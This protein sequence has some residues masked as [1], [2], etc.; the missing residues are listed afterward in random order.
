MAVEDCFLTGGLSTAATALACTE[1]VRVGIGLLPVPLRNVALTAMEVATLHRL[2]P[3]RPVIGVGHGVQSWMGQVG[4]RVASPV[5]LLGEYLDALRALLAGE[6]VSA[7][8]RYVQLDDVALDQPPAEAP[9][10]FAGAR[11]P[12]SIELCGAHADG[13]LLDSIVD[14]AGVRAARALIEAGRAAAGRSDEHHVVAALLAATGPDA[15]ARVAA[16]RT[17]EHAAGAGVAGDAHAVADAVLAL[18]EAGAD[19]VVLAPTADADPEQF[20][21]FVADEVRPLVG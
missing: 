4:A 8:G 7:R 15:A 21:R 5:G 18:A 19:S 2:F 10:I 12:R 20:I 6:R 13:T 9:K 3:D 14:P 11:G 1:R 17:P 16:E